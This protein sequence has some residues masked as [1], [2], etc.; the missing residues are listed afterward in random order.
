MMR[1][2][3]HFCLI[4]F[5]LISVETIIFHDIRLI[6]VDPKL[7]GSNEFLSTA[8]STHGFILRLCT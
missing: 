4:Q 1:N 3:F 5:I 8:Y 7:D 6:L 2:T